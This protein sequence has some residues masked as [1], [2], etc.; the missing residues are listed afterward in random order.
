MLLIKNKIMKSLKFILYIHLMVVFVCIL[1][2][3]ADAQIRD[4]TPLN[5]YTVEADKYFKKAQQQKG[6]AI[7][8]LIV[9]GVITTT[10]LIIR[11]GKDVPLWDGILLISG[12]ACMLA[13][14]G[15]F[16]L[17]AYYKRKANLILR[18]EKVLLNPQSNLK[19]LVCFGVKINL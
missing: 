14:A 3:N 5:K 18:N 6:S 12:P 8:S 1:T 17:S 19:H 11:N 16:I 4:I 9:G 15:G 2:L 7:I 10:G 13:G